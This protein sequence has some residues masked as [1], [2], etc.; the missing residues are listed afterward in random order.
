[1]SAEGT[2]NEVNAQRVAGFR[3]RQRWVR[4]GAWEDGYTVWWSD[5]VANDWTEYFPAVSSA[6][7]R[8]AAIVFCGEHDCE[9]GFDTDADQFHTAAQAWFGQTTR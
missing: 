3:T 2:G 8:V 7:A 4:V 1:L 6:L 5:G 9:V